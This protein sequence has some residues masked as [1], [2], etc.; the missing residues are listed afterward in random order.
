MSLPRFRGTSP[1]RS[2]GLGRILRCVAHS[3]LPGL[4]EPQISGGT[5]AAGVT[6]SS[7]GVGR[8]RQP[9]EEWK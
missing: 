8:C 4:S 1:P 2:S 6:V 7:R 5:G 9:P 3:A